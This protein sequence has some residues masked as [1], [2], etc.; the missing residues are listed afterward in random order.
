MTETTAI[1]I[2]TKISRN[3]YNNFIEV[4]L[5][6]ILERTVLNVNKNQVNG[7]FKTQMKVSFFD[8]KDKEEIK[9][10]EISVNP[11]EARLKGFTYSMPISTNMKIELI[12]NDERMIIPFE[13]FKL[14]DF[15]VML[16]SKYCN[17]YSKSSVELVELGESPEE[18]GGYFI[19]DGSEKI[20]VS[21][22][23]SKKNLITT[24]FKQYSDYTEY[25]ASLQSSI[26]DSKRPEIHRIFTKKDNSIVVR[27]P[28]FA[29]I[30]REFPLVVVLRA[31]GFDNDKEILKYICGNLE[32]DL[33]KRI[34][35]LFE[36]FT[37]E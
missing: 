37:Q 34:M 36:C 6:K 10:G 13:N 27:I 14:L 5:P 26:D 1:D 4:H 12:H 8:S 23:D 3:S 33:S 24:N 9:I 11:N 32:T 18:R 16:H 7:E 29:V 31:C 30:G 35:N 2:L 21:Q 22:E 20:I 17:L 19:I 28:Y 25:S 15:P